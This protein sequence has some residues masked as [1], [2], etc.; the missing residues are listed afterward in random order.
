M[1]IRISLDNFQTKNFH[2]WIKKGVPSQKY[3]NSLLNSVDLNKTRYQI[4]P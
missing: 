1:H 2:F 4:S 3:N